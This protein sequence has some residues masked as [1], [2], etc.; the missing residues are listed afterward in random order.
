MEQLC[1][2]RLSDVKFFEKIKTI[3]LP[4][5]NHKDWHKICDYRVILNVDEPITRLTKD[6]FFNYWGISKKR[7]NYVYDLKT[8][9]VFK[10]KFY[11]QKTYDKLYDKAF[12]EGKLND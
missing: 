3:H 7:N 11:T 9:I 5:V 2:F 8:R 4:I 10:Q 1:V 12:K 6:D